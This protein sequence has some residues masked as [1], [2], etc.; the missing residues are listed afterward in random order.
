MC[1]FFVLDYN[2]ISPYATFQISPSK[3]PKI[4][5]QYVCTNC[6]ENLEICNCNRMVIPYIH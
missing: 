1:I 4:N 3:S 6:G 5:K 2:E